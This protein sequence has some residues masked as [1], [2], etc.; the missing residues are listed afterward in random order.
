MKKS[1]PYIIAF[2]AGLFART[3]ISA[4]NGWEGYRMNGIDLICGVT[5]IVMVWSFKGAFMPK[6]KKSRR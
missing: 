3:A 1:L 6:K 5:C 4:L 2:I